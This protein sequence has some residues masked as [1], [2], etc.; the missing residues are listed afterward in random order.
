MPPVAFA[1]LALNLISVAWKEW[2]QKSTMPPPPLLSGSLPL[3]LQADITPSN[4][5]TLDDD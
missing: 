5:E 2:G 4:D 3:F 1:I